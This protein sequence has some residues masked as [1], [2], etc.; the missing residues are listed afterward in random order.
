VVLS[1]IR[2]PR[3]AAVRIYRAGT[4]A[5]ATFVL[6]G[7]TG[8]NAFTD[9]SIVPGTSYRYRLKAVGTNG[10]EGRASSELTVQV[11]AVTLKAPVAPVWEGYLSLEAGVGLKWKEQEG[12]DIVAYNVYR[13]TPPD[14]EFRLLASVQG[15]NYI[16][17]TAVP[18]RQ[19]S[20]A[21]SAL[22]SAFRETSLSAPLAVTFQPRRAPAER[23][24]VVEWKPRRTRLVAIV[25]R[26]DQ[27][28]LRP[29][30][31]AVGPLSGNVY[32]S[33]SGLNRIMVFDGQGGFVRSLGGTPDGEGEFGRLLG[34][35]VDHDEAVYAVDAGREAVLVFEGGSGQGRHL[36]LPSVEHKYRPGLVDCAVTDAG[37][38]FV[39]DNTNNRILVTGAG[40]GAEVIGSTGFGMG[41]FSAPTFTALD[42]QGNLYIADSLNGRV[43]VFSP[44]G[45]F[46]RAFGRMERGPVLLARPKGLAVREN[47]EVLVADSWLNAIEVFDAAGQPRAILVDEEGHPLD[48]G[49]PNGIALGPGNRL[50]IA[51]RLSARLQ[52]RE[53]VDDAR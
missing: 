7:E 47:G 43:Q 23:K 5:K 52:I 45:T 26:G 25:T 3:F 14:P 53:I 21:L 1:W 24:T 35:A 4:D 13:Q 27:A 22:D 50:Y 6:V 9:A 44:A 16:D 2:D 20:Y 41:Q 17:T 46:S 48:L 34:L 51:E 29:A 30:D 36:D 31:V 15:T 28:L 39:V 38:A 40:A 32:L 37:R 8:K 12:A 33:D 49:S 18:D 11:P 19:V 42:R 10:S